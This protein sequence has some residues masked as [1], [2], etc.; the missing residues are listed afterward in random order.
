MQQKTRTTLENELQVAF[1][2]M[3]QQGKGMKR[4]FEEGRIDPLE[5]FSLSLQPIDRETNIVDHI[6]NPLT[7]RSVLKAA[8]SGL[9]IAQIKLLH[10]LQYQ[11]LAPKHRKPPDQLSADLGGRNAVPNSA[12]IK[13]N[14]NERCGHR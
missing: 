5:L 13:N 11:I 9:H 14:M 2:Q 4:P 8:V 6:F 1:S 12:S 7:P 3:S 10:L